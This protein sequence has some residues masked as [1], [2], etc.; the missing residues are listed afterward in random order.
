MLKNVSGLAWLLM[1]CSSE[2][3]QAQKSAKA[4]HQ[5]LLYN[6]LMT[7]RY[8]FSKAMLFLDKQLS[9]KK[10]TSQWFAWLMVIPQI[11]I[12]KLTVDLGI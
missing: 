2:V 9:V 5:T 4:T 3:S 8:Y 12:V 7:N 6:N 10:P 1:D 11:L